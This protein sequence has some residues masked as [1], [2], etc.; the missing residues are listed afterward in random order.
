MSEGIVCLCEGICLR[1]R[2][3]IPFVVSTYRDIKHFVRGRN[4]QVN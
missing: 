3:E 2:V 1:D 4:S